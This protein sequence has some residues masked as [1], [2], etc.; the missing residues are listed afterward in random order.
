MFCSYLTFIQIPS[1]K[2]VLK[3]AKI[4]YCTVTSVVWEF[5]LS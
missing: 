5:Q 1:E 3:I 4:Y 2:E